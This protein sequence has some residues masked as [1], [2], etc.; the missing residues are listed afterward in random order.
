MVAQVQ[1]D[2]RTGSLFQMVLI[3]CPFCQWQLPKTE[4]WLSLQLKWGVARLLIYCPRLST[5]L[6]VL[7]V[8]EQ[9]L[10]LVTDNIRLYRLNHLEPVRQGSW[11]AH[12]IGR[13]LEPYWRRLS[14]FVLNLLRY[15]GAWVEAVVARGVVY[16]V[17]FWDRAQYVNDLSQAQYHSPFPT[18]NVDR[19]VRWGDR[20]LEYV[21]SEDQQHILGSGDYQGDVS[22]LPDLLRSVHIDDLE[23][24]LHNSTKHPKDEDLTWVVAPRHP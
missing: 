4:H 16:V 21:L 11:L 1:L 10:D 19:V 14:A 23:R 7:V 5:P 18:W 20:P 2:P 13:L 6:Q 22:H 9:A 15:V 17:N 12:R 8:P 3:R 24:F